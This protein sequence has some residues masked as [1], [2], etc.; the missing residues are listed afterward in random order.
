MKK[1]KSTMNIMKYITYIII[2]AVILN[3]NV[4]AISIYGKVTEEVEKGKNTTIKFNVDKEYYLQIKEVVIEEGKDKV[5][6]VSYKT[7]ELL[8]NTVYLEVKGLVKGSAKLKIKYIY[9]DTRKIEETANY[10]N[11]LVEIIV[12]EKANQN[13]PNKPN[14][15]QSIPKPESGSNNQNK[16]NSNSSNNSN[17]SNSITQKTEKPKNNDD[18]VIGKISREIKQD[19]S[20]G[21]KN[22]Q[23]AVKTANEN[24]KNESENIKEEVKPVEEVKENKEETKTTEKKKES[25]N[26][27][28]TGALQ[29][30]KKDEPKSLTIAGVGA[31]V[32]VAIGGIIY[33]VKGG[34][35]GIR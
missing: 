26:Y 29:Y 5:K 34:K 8:P 1:L 28:A 19:F 21:K 20:K 27:K 32:V 2:L 33:F 14:E 23:K 9:A 15:N 18:L 11:K 3:L 13:T 6:V 10:K 30:E 25:S 17:N 4:F 16:P 22:N 24:K 31:I 7:D 12:T 35:K